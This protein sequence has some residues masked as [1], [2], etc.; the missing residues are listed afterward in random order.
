MGVVDVGAAYDAYHA[1]HIAAARHIDVVGTV[2]YV[3]VATFVDEATADAAH[4][5]GANRDLTG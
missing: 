2:A 4:T 5:V 1:A 3:A